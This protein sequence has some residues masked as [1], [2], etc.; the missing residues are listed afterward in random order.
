MNTLCP[1][2]G[3]SV[4]GQESGLLVVGEV[5]RQF[6]DGERCVTAD[7][8]VSFPRGR[9][10]RAGRLVLGQGLRTTELQQIHAFLVERG[11]SAYVRVV[12]N[13]SRRVSQTSV[14]KRL[15]RNVMVTTPREVGRGHFELDLVVDGSCAELSDHTTGVHLQGMLLIEA[16]RQAFMACG[17]IIASTSG[18]EEF[19]RSDYSHVLREFHVRYRSRLFPLPT[20][21]VVLV[22]DLSY[23][24]TID[25]FACET[26]IQFKQ[27]DELA[28]LISCKA[29]SV[30]SRDLVKQEKVESVRALDTFM[31]SGEAWEAP[32]YAA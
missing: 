21:V 28:V 27:L 1:R 5:F 25:V 15:E 8:L 22:A 23:M 30:R 13:A 17:P 2:Q 26:E 16:A 31:H 6:A 29:I 14:H 24:Q 10:R 32:L 9:V 3:S 12:E 7:D 18:F 19:A 4:D 11:L 20:K